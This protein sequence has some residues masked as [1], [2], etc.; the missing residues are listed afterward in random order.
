MTRLV[1]PR[2]ALVVIAGIGVL[3]GA[4][5][6]SGYLA[7]GH[8]RFN[9]HDG[10][11]P[12]EGS[13]GRRPRNRSINDGV[14]ASQTVRNGHA[15]SRWPNGQLRSDVTYRQDAY[16]GEYRTYYE[17]G[18]PYELRHYVNGHEEGVQRS[19]SETGV[20]YLNYEVR[21]GRRFGLVNASPC[22]TVGDASSASSNRDQVRLARNKASDAPEVGLER[23]GTTADGTR[24][25]PAT[26][27]NEVTS[28]ASAADRLP[29]YGE[30]AFQPHW[31]PVSHRVASFTLPTQTGATI[32]DTN[33]RGRPYV[34]SFIYTQCAAV[35][36]ILVRQLARVQNALGSH[37]ARIV[38]FSVTPDTD[39]PAI[40]AQ[41]G[42]ERGIY[43]RSWSLVTGSKHTIYTLA[44]DSYFADDSRV[45]TSPDD[46]TAFL[47]TEKLVLVDGDGRLRGIYNGTQPFA[48]DQLIQDLRQLSN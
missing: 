29:Y 35:C 31:T 30:P 15:Q 1:L 5:I 24:D 40:L 13:R 36:P 23:T 28:H 37:T 11:E 46:V 17:S 34:A 9:H 20:L 16:D 41:F 32:S 2:V 43:S 18:A 22:N 10:S 48:V 14:P 4:R 47:H 26:S 33:L 42:K 44:R 8:N 38:S 45:G 19:W 3:V 25:E 39:T 27:R 6:A 21:S 7:N 12:H